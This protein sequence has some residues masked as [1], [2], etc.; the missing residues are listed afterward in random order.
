MIEM[1]FS[2]SKVTKER[3]CAL[4]PHALLS[5]Q[6]LDCVGS[7]SLPDLLSDACIWYEYPVTKLNSQHSWGANGMI[8]MSI[9]HLFWPSGTS[10]FGR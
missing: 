9:G 4:G 1:L 2:V 6:H 5:K 7:R 10:A 3:Y 8:S